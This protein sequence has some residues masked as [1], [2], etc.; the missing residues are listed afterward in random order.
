VSYLK[1]DT[2]TSNIKKTLT[3]AVTDCTTHCSVTG[4]YVLTFEYDC[5]PNPKALASPNPI[6]IGQSTIISVTVRSSKPYTYQ[7][8]ESKFNTLGGLGP[9]SVSPTTTTTYTITA[10]D[11]VDL[12][13]TDVNSVVVV[14][15]TLPTA[16]V[17]NSTICVG[18]SATLTASNQDGRSCTYSWTN[19]S[20]NST[21]SGSQITYTSP[22][23]PNLAASINYTITAT[24]G[25]QCTDVTSATV[26]VN[27]LPI[28]TFATLNTDTICLNTPSFG[29]LGGSPAVPPSPGSGYYSGTGVSANTFN[30]MVSDTGTFAIFYHYT[31]GNGCIDSNQ[32]N[33]TVLGSPV[34]SLAGDT[35]LCIGESTTIQSAIQNP[36]T[37]KSTVWDDP[38][39]TTNTSLT[40]TPPMG[41]STY[42]FTVTNK[43]N[44]ATSHPFVVTVNPYPTVTFTSDTT[45][46]CVPLTVNFTDHTI[47]TGGKY[48]WDF[49]DLLSGL[50]N[51]SDIV[52]PSHNFV[53]DG[54][55]DISLS[56][57]TLP[58]CTTPLTVPGMIHVYPVPKAYFIYSPPAPSSF[59]P[60]VLFTDVSS[61][62]V[63]YSQNEWNFA[64]TL[65]SEDLVTGK[66]VVRHSFSTY[67]YF[68]VKLKVK[69]ENCWDSTVI[70]V[71]VKADHSFY[72]PTA[73]TP[74]GD[75][76]N[77]GFIPKGIGI[78]PNSFQM[79]IYDRWGE[80]IYQTTDLNQ[81]W[82]GKKANN[83]DDCPQGIYG[84]LMMF[85]DMEGNAYKQEGVVT[86]IK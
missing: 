15:N 9:F 42:T 26:T 27:A 13:K 81:P 19:L 29:I 21:A 7:W 72:V 77:E 47:P 86:L 62:D 56:V 67:G 23:S 66:Q 51:T 82:N 69:N 28:V 75:N 38:S 25:N 76:L 14:V 39:H 2:P 61:G 36:S 63:L 4:S 5:R 57:T 12:T 43:G 58:H 35:L 10:T 65:S 48:V 24:D 83:K 37:I 34:F 71:H 6:C 64:D 70:T 18:Q 49:G 11:A 1:P 55:F 80:Q 22:P 79:F 84:W 52:N 44:C 46:G 60:D 31:D 20:D 59:K 17:T 45:Q 8:S 73:F 32:T 3:G 53:N 54:D 74:N 33:I 16:S 78:D 30:P 41:T 85:N 68:P 40:V 50:N